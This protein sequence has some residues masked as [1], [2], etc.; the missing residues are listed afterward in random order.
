VGFHIPGYQRALHADRNRN[1]KKRGAGDLSRS[2][3]FL[4]HTERGWPQNDSTTFRRQLKAELLTTWRDE[5]RETPIS[6]RRAPLPRNSFCWRLRRDQCEAVSAGQRAQS[7]LGSMAVSFL[8]AGKYSFVIALPR[9]PSSTVRVG[10]LCT[11][12]GSGSEL[13]AT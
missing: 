10:D 7:R 5:V 11:G 6:T 2:T 13:T 12:S 9:R 3:R 1:W 4:S 8:L